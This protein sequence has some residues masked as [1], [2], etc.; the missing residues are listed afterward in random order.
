[1]VA[2]VRVDY[3]G[4][5]WIQSAFHPFA[6]VA[7]IFGYIPIPDNINLNRYDQYSFD[8]KLPFPVFNPFMGI[9]G[10]NGNVGYSFSPRNEA[11]GEWTCHLVGDV[12]RYKQKGFPYEQYGIEYTNPVDRIDYGAEGYLKAMIYFG[13]FRG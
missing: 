1:M 7:Y 4:D 9:S 3:M 5:G 11:A 12:V 10:L 2:D 8:F 6:K 13:G